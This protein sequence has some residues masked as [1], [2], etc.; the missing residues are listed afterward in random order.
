MSHRLTRA[1]CACAPYM[2]V[3][4][5]R[6]VPPHRRH[7]ADRKVNVTPFE[8]NLHVWRQLWR[9]IERSDV[10]V[11]IVDSRNPLLFW[12]PDVFTYAKEINPNKA[13]LLIIN[14]ADYLTVE[15]RCVRF[16]RSAACS[17][18]RWRSH[19][20]RFPHQQ[21]VGEVF[22]RYRRKLCFLLCPQGAE[23]AGR[24]TP[25]PVRCPLVLAS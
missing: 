20:H 21:S 23:E 5:L 16:A 2:S 4:V 17:P 7:E 14:K 10:I 15:M 8:K 1:A 24:G 19:I 12:C 18:A 9:V 22:R 25:G 13:A 6:V 3:W 11:Q